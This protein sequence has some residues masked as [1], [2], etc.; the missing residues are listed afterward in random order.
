MP[1]CSEVTLSLY[2]CADVEGQLQP[3]ARSEIPDMD[4]DA[5]NGS[6]LITTTIKGGGTPERRFR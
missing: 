1:D 6:N 5:D 4:V 2:K 3:T